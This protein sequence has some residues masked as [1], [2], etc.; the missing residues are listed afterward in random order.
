MRWIRELRRHYLARVGV[1]LVA[2][3]AARD[4]FALDA[5]HD[6]EVGAQHCGIIGE[7]ENFRHWNALLEGGA[8]DQKFVAAI[9]FDSLR[10]G[11][12]P[13]HHA[14]RF[15]ALRALRRAIERPDFARGAARHLVQVRDFHIPEIALLADESAQPLV[16]FGR[17]HIVLRIM[18]MEASGTAATSSGE[19]RAES[20]APRRRRLR[21]S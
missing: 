10:G 18:K 11:V 2:Q 5:L 9:A 8:Q 20:R 12:A 4:G 1:L 21:S 13:Q 3:Q 16:Q 7:P 15:G 14:A 17:I 19:A 6:E